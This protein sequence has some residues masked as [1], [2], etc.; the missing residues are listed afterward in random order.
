MVPE[1]M[2]WY[3]GLWFSV[4]PDPQLPGSF[5]KPLVLR[6]IIILGKEQSVWAVNFPLGLDM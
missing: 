4:G 3:R 5:G 1:V 6:P 2:S